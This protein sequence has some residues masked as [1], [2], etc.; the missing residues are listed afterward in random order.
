MVL[1]PGQ[2][3]VD[4]MVGDSSNQ[5]TEDTDEEINSG[6]THTLKVSVTV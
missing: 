6:V 2:E 4:E 1:T 3:A 5:W